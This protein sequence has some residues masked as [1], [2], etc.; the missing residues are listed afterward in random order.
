[1]SS[2]F[3]ALILAAAAIFTISCGKQN[4]TNG[5]LGPENCTNHVDDNADGKTDCLDPKCFADAA[6][7]IISERC[8]NGVDDNGDGRTDCADSFCEG[9]ACGL[10]CLCSGGVPIIGTTGGG[11]GGGGATGG[12]TGGGA[13]GG[14]TGGGTTGGGTGG[15]ATGGGTGGGTTGGGTGGGTTGGGT[16]GGTTGGGTG[17]GT[18]GG[19]TGGGTTGGGTGG[20]TTG[21]G[22]GGGTTGGGT[23]G[24]TTGGGTGGGT[25]GGGTGGGVQPEANCAD[26]IDNDGDN[27]TDCDDSDCV[28]ITCGMGCRCALNRRTEVSCN[29]GSDNDFDTRTD[30]A[31]TDCFGAGTE[32]CNDGVDNNC[33][34][35]IDCGDTS[36]NGSPQC[37]GLQD[38]KPC[39]LDAQCAGGD[40]I[41]ESTNGAPNGF[42]SNLTSCT[43]STNAGC[44][45]GL[46]VAGSGFNAC[47]PRCTGTGISGAG[48]CRAGYVCYDQDTDLGNN[49][50]ICLIA[51]SNDSECAGSGSGYGCNPWSKK[52]GPVD[53]GLRR[54][55]D[56]CTANSQCESGLCF[57][58]SEFP[59]GYCSGLCRGD[60]NNCASGNFC[61]FNAAYGDNT[62][63]C[64]QSCT[65]SGQSQCL[66]PFMT[67]FRTAPSAST[68]A[69]YC[70]TQGASCQFNSDCCSGSCG[71]FSAFQ[72]DP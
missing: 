30:C 14:G 34:R 65:V 46:C 10:N 11:A 40:C 24:G 58:G 2:R 4:P 15:G 56:D 25:T 35:A 41:A 66:N 59:G 23:G 22:T 27:A 8:D 21:G 18:T 61:S 48:A 7:K 37:N 26:N 12:G 43:V 72:C 6:C 28:G 53:R 39:L 57:G 64:Y 51:C 67:C 63:F 5:P 55:G 17:G 62:G 50:S 52:C 3:H 54:Y 45:G 38:G 69:C 1:M 31:D 16:G 20:G 29:D 13:T 70:L 9:Q 42:C 33:D 60:T 44:N 68:R 47:S 71:F 36:C 49:N 32:I 19:G